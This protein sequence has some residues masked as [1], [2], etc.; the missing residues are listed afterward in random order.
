[1]DCNICSN[2][3]NFFSLRKKKQTLNRIM[4][5]KVSPMRPVEVMCG[6]LDLHNLDSSDQDGFFDGDS[7]VLARSLDKDNR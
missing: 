6:W 7:V 5:Q 1:M 4:V 3:G 2:F